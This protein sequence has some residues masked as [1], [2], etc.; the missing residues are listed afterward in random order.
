M[1]KIFSDLKGKGLMVCLDDIVIFSK[2]KDEHIKLV[3]KVI[4]RINEN[5]FRIGKKVK[6]SI[7]KIK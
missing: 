7:V 5:N 4:E 2:D 1:N 3:N 6:F